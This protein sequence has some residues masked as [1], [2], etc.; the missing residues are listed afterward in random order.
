M[1]RSPV[2][3]SSAIPRRSRKEPAY[4]QSPSRAPAR[5]GAHRSSQQC[6][7]RLTFRVTDTAHDACRTARMQARERRRLKRKFI[8]HAGAGK[9]CLDVGFYVEEVDGCA[10]SFGS[11]H[12]SGARGPQ[13]TPASVSI[14]TVPPPSWASKRLPRSNRRM[15]S[16]WRRW[17]TERGVQQPRPQRHAHDRKV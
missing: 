4:M 15:R 12:C 14:S 16:C 6:G 9:Q 11:P 17:F 7:F 1:L 8:R 13:A 2:A 3:R 5:D 10:R